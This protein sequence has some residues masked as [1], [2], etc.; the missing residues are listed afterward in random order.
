MNNT[1]RYIIAGILIFSIILLQ[2]IYLKWLGY[3]DDYDDVGQS[4]PSKT[5]PVD[6]SFFEEE[7]FNV[8]RYRVKI[9]KVLNNYEK[10]NTPKKL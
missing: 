1:T 8:I 9:V 3:G 6:K 2:P 4:A 5:L 7:K 10:R